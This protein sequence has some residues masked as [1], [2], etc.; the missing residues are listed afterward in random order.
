MCSDFTVFSP[1]CLTSGPGYTNF[2]LAP[3]YGISMNTAED[4]LNL[5]QI[6]LI[7][8]CSYKMRNNDDVGRTI[9]TE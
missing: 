6:T 7:S 9:I 3:E 4:G 1:V 5:K 2:R 8:C